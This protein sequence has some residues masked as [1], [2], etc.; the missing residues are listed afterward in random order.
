KGSAFGT[1]GEDTQLSNEQFENNLF[2]A[3]LTCDPSKP[4]WLEN[5]SRSIGRNHIPE[6]LWWKM[7]NSTLYNI[8]VNIEIRL[9]RVLQYYSDN[10]NVDV[11][12]ESFTKI[13]KR[14]G[15][16]DYQ[17]AIHALECNDL[18][19]AAAIALKY[20]DKSYD[21][22]VASWG[23]ANLR[24]IDGCDR[25]MDAANKLNEKLTSI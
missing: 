5:E 7:R 15:G 16:L 14:L 9:D 4:I 24:Q 20:Y 23:P 10:T 19:T 2:E 12:K 3:F 8:E 11:L 6:S 25:V 22:Q 13:K 17:V 21:H 18:R 1:I